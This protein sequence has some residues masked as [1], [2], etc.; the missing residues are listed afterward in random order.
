MEWTGA[1]FVLYGLDSLKDWTYGVRGIMC[2][3]HNEW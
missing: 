1:G 2:I 3:Q